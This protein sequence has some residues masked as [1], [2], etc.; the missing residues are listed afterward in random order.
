[1]DLDVVVG[2]VLSVLTGAAGGL[3]LYLLGEQIWR[4]LKWLYSLWG[5]GRR[6]REAL[7]CDIEN[8][9]SRVERIKASRKKAQDKCARAVEDWKA[10]KEEHNRLRVVLLDILGVEEDYSDSTRGLG[11]RAKEMVEEARGILRDTVLRGSGGVL[12]GDL[13]FLAAQVRTQ[14]AALR[15]RCAN[16]KTQL[17]VLCALTEGVSDRL[18]KIVVEC[19]EAAQRTVDAPPSQGKN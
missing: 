18:G 16:Q 5:E 8:L 3:I 7:E 12:D 19:A 1:M 17:S 10:L 4:F 14:N 6:Q 13:L 9:V 11:Q 15:N 2:M